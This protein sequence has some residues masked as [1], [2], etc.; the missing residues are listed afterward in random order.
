MSTFQADCTEC[1]ATFWTRLLLLP[2]CDK[3]LKDWWETPDDLFGMYDAAYHFIL[4]AAANHYNHKVPVWFGPGGV[5]VDALAADWQPYLK[6][7]N[8]WLNPPYAR[9]K[10][11]QFVEKAI[12]EKRMSWRDCNNPGEI[13]CLLPADTSTKL[14]HDVVKLNGEIAFLRGRIK[15]KG[16]PGK[17]KF[18]SMV[19]VF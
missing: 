12:A 18:A 6:E 10:Q 9:G 1:G 17:P 5:H 13:V 3:C 15:F 4:D 11:R 14:F 8:I 2:V 7:G 16:A 19:V